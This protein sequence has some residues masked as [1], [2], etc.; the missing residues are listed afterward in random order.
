MAL[1][2][3]SNDS[4]AGKSGRG[5]L[6]GTDKSD[7]V[8][9]LE[10]D[11]VIASGDGKDLIIGGGGNDAV[12]GGAGDDVGIL[13]KGDDLFGWNP[14]DGND[15]IEG[16]EG[17]DTMLFNGANVAEQIDMSAVGK[18]FRFFRNVANVVMDTDELEQVD[19]NAFGGEDIITV[20]DL[21]GTDIKQINIDLSAFGS[22]DGDGAAD[23]VI[24]NGSDQADIITVSGTPGDVTVLGLGAEIKII[25]AELDRDLL[26]INGLAG[27]DIIDASNLAAGAMQLLIDGGEGNDIL[28]GGGEDDT[29]IGG[30][31][32]DFVDGK[33]GDD[34][35][36]LGAGEDVFL[37]N[38][39]EGSDTID[40]GAGYDTMVFN[41]SGGDET[42]DMLA[43]GERFTFLRNIGSVVM[44]THSLEQVD[45][46]ALGGTDTIN[47]NDLTGTDI[48]KIGLDLGGFDADGGDGES[49]TVNVMGSANNDVVQIRGSANDVVVAGL[50]ATVTITDADADLDSLVVSGGNGNDRIIAAGLRPGAIQL[51]IKGGAGNDRLIGSTSADIL[52][53]GDGDDTLLGRKGADRLTGGEGQDDFRYNSLNHGG[54]TITD[55]VAA[56][57]RI[58]IRATGFG[59]GVVA[60]S[61]ISSDQFVLG[62]AAT[63]ATN[64]FIYNSSSGELF[65]DRDGSGD[66]AQTLIA[67]LTG[68]PALSNADLVLI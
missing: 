64:R 32:N 23:T 26:V 22:A 8:F 62:T 24:L 19:F 5:N 41:G 6:L 11:D 56:E 9:G 10:G 61:E 29:I 59:G 43:N 66:A 38:P 50:A 30:E 42:I 13:G 12:F 17:Y 31:G 34:R 54:D 60:G 33:G 3:G 48:K 39:G 4:D 40:G 15:R 27:D 46:Q 20:N 16:G 68:A 51:T 1:I 21:T 28:I 55:F 2:I 53:G 36:F 67:T 57:D 14:G 45:F 37:W 44:D 63:S 25:G 58:L 65:F 47:I 18:R 49:D 35:A 52:M 7:I